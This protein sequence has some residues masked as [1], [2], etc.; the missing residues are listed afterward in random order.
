MIMGFIIRTPF[1]IFVS[2]TQVQY[3]VIKIK[4]PLS[5]TLGLSS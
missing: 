1:G 2:A 5:V 3:I 4:Q